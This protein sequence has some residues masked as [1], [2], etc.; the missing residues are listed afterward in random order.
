LI[1][2]PSS[3]NTLFRGIIQAIESFGSNLSTNRVAIAVQFARIEDSLTSA[4]K[5]LLETIP[6]PYALDLTD[7]DDL[8]FQVNKPMAS[9]SVPGVQLNFVRNW[10]LTRFQMMNFAMSASIGSFTP[11][12]SS[13]MSPSEMAQIGAI[14]NIEVNNRPIEPSRPLSVEE[15]KDILLESLKIIE[16]EQGNIGLNVE[17]FRDEL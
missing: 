1:E 13:A 10:S 6:A 12:L 2:D 5:T 15:Q 17:G 16:E 7:E 3:L 4:T 11:Q 14:V 9:E 8:I